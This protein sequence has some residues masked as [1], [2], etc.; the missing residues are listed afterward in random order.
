LAEGVE[1]HSPKLALPE[2]EN[3]LHG[4]LTGDIVEVHGRV[5]QLDRRIKVHD[6]FPI[7]ASAALQ[8]EDFWAIAAR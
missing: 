3:V 6:L 5:Q 2:Q 1:D 4:P 8:L 7:V